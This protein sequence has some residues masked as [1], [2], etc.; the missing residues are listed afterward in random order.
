M[1]KFLLIPIVYKSLKT[2]ILFLMFSVIIGSARSAHQ[3]LGKGFQEVIYQRYLAIEFDKLDIFYLREDNRP[4]Y[5]EVK[6][7]GT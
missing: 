2:F 7:V 4:I 1:S 3:K 6:Q 5:H